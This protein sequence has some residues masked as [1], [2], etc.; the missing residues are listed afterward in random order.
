MVQG[1]LAV[2]IAH[3]LLLLLFYLSFFGLLKFPALLL[4]L[5][6]L[7]LRYELLLRELWRWLRRR[8]LH[9]LL[10]LG[11]P[12]LYLQGSVRPTLSVRPPL[13]LRLLDLLAVMLL[14]NAGRRGVLC[15]GGGQLVF[16]CGVEYAVWLLL[17]A[18]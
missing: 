9:K 13:L 12:W 6:L 15:R 7:L 4:L 1:L 16:V 10:P 5:F 8:L 17:L 2:G 18:R 14:V 11:E 3:L